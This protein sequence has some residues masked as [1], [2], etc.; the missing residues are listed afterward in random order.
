MKTKQPIIRTIYLYLISAITIIIILIGLIGITN[1]IL[2]EYIFNV[3]TWGELDEDFTY[4]CDPE[5][6]MHIDTSSRNLVDDKPELTAEEKK[7]KEKNCIK[8]EKEKQQ[9][10]DANDFKRDMVT[11]ISMLLISLP[12]YLFHWNLIKKDN[13]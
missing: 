12:L 2:K 11:W 7:Q 3:K 8:E 13:E 9:R 1:L 10:R 5:M 4:I 6:M